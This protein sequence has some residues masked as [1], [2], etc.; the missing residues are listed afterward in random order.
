MFLGPVLGWGKACHFRPGKWPSERGLWQVVV[1]CKL[2]Q[3]SIEKLGVGP[4]NPPPPSP[5][6]SSQM[7]WHSQG[8]GLQGKTPK[9]HNPVLLLC[10]TGSTNDAPP[11]ISEGNRQH[12][13]ERVTEDNNSK[14]RSLLILILHHPGLCQVKSSYRALAVPKPSRGLE[15]LF[16][17]PSA[18]PP[19]EFPYRWEIMARLP[20]TPGRRNSVPSQ[21]TC[22]YWSGRGHLAFKQI[23]L[24]SLITFPVSRSSFLKLYAE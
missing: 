5:R 11:H 6:I 9:A 10:C 24:L 18:P 19:L 17:R 2:G 16:F 3:V 7:T 20:F 22:S 1:W 21:T 8:M 15:L 12:M 23:Q 14:C 4:D 13:L